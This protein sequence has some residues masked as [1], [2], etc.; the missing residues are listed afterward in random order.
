MQVEIFD[1]DETVI[2]R[3]FVVNAWMDKTTSYSVLAASCTGVEDAQSSSSRSVLMS[4]TI[5]YCATT[6]TVL[7]V[8]KINCS[9]TF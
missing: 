6:Y 5:G 2:E 4:V 8:Y 1:V 7:T 9:K 3:V